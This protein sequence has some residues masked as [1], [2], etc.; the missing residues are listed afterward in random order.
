[1]KKMG[2]K[3]RPFYRICAMDARSPR[4][5][6]VI[7][8]LGYYDPKV[9]ETDARAILNGERIDY[10]LSVGAEASEKVSVLIKKYGASGT[11]LEQ[12]KAALE[13]VKLAKP[14]APPPRVVPKR[15]PEEPVVA[16][17]PPA[18]DVAETA[19]DEAPADANV[20]EG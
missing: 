1:M 15:E 5:G 17:P 3:R 7:E 8:E 4:D 11:H 14:M 19:A 16:A 2:R 13:R 18:A 10:W 6:K 20:A 9:K 12:Q